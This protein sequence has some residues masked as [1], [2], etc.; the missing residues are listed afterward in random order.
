MEKLP[1]GKVPE[2]ADFLAYLD[3]QEIRITNW[4]KAVELSAPLGEDFIELVAGGK[5]KDVVEKL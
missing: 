4:H 2:R 3:D 1:G 5:I